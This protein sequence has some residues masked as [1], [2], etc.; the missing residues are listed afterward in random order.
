MAATPSHLERGHHHRLSAGIW[1]LMGSGEGVRQGKEKASQST[2]AGD[3]LAVGIESMGGEGGVLVG[4]G[5][6]MSGCRALIA[7]PHVFWLDA[8]NTLEQ[9]VVPTMWQADRTERNSAHSVRHHRAQARTQ[10]KFQ[11]QSG[12]LYIYVAF[13]RRT[14]PSLLISSSFPWRPTRE[15]REIAGRRLSTSVVFLALLFFL[16]QAMVL[17]K[18]VAFLLLV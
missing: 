7:K 18:P 13:G 10:T 16:D 1:I 11:R 17:D 12:A 6:K 4:W 15:P 14:E 2:V 5:L 3:G 9:N 8:V